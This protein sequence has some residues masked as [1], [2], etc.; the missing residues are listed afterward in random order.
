MR[1]QSDGFIGGWSGSIAAS[2][3]ATSARHGRGGRAD[4]GA[5]F[6]W[7]WQMPSTSSSAVAGRTETDRGG[8]RTRR[9][10]ARNRRRSCRETD[11][12]LLATAASMLGRGDEQVQVL[13]RAYHRYLEDGDDDDALNCAIWLGIHLML[14]A[15]RRPGR[16]LAD[17]RRAAA[18]AGRA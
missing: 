11:L 10:R 18:G 4:G 7:P 5:R 13:E 15:E 12:E 9:W 2:P 14:A 17:A 1:S 6:N 3:T 16:R 8:R